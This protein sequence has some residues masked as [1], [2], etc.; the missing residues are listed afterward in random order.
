MFQQDKRAYLVVALVAVLC[1]WP[2]RGSRAQNQVAAPQRALILG[3]AH[4]AFQVSDLIKA[5]A[6]YGEL[7]GYDEPFQIRNEDN[8]LALTYFKV[9]DRQYIGA[10]SAALVLGVISLALVL[11]ADMLRGK[12]H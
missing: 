7:L 6:F 5:R 3:V 8:S 11:G 1:W 12:E 2:T 4:I 9:N 10:Y